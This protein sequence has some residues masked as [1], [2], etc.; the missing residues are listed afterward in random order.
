MDVANTH[1][2]ILM[3]SDLLFD[4]RRIQRPK[5]EV[6]RFKVITINRAMV[7]LVMTR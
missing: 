6:I 4:T 3:H 2:G 7:G 1:D 5:F